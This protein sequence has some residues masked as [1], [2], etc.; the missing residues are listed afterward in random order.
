MIRVACRRNLLRINSPRNW[1]CLTHAF[2]LTVFLS[3]CAAR[4]PVICTAKDGGAQTT[5]GDRRCEMRR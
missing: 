4:G 2:I 1:A 5:S 3:S